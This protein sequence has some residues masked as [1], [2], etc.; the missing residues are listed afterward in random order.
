MIGDAAEG[1]GVPVETMA[2]S[3]GYLYA[4]IRDGEPI[5]RAT[6]QLVRMGAITPEV[7]SKM[8]EM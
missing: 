7:A 5:K 3:I 4:M 8:E 2:E 6:K 1:V